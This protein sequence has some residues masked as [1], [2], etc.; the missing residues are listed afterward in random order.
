M[1][2]SKTTRV[3]AA[4]YLRDAVDILLKKYAKQLKRGAR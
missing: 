3:T 1:K 2:L 4:V